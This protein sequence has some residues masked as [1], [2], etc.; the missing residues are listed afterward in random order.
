MKVSSFPQINEFPPVLQTTG[1]SWVTYKTPEPS[2]QQFWVGTDRDGCKWLTKLRG[3]FSG[4]REIVFARLA[5]RMG[6][7][8]QTSIFVQL[9]DTALGVL[10]VRPN[11]R[12]H[13]V[14]WF[15]EEHKPVKCTAKCP[16]S[17]TK[18]EK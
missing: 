17:L 10:P 16:Y 1:W 5:Q 6:W 3:G 8:C 4:Y 12:T 7:S 18:D 9:D 11:C 14:H 2:S 15:L 13:A